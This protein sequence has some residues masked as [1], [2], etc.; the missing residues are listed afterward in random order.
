MFKP[1]HVYIEKEALSYK[2]TKELKKQL[3]SRHL[4][5]D[6]IEN[7]QTK[8]A[9][10]RDTSGDEVLMISVYKNQEFRAA[11]PFADYAIP[12]VS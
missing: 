12:F 7:G 9:K 1:Y 11:P 6:V 4:P 3:E 8:V 10:G 5:I 2:Q